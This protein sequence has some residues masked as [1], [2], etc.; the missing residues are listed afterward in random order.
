MSTKAMSEEMERLRAALAKINA[1]RNSI[2]GCQKVN[3]S[4]HVYPLVAALEAAGFVGQ[5]YAEARSDA[6]TLLARA[7]SAEAGVDELRVEV[8]RLNKMLDVCSGVHAHNVALKDERG[9]LRVDVA[10]LL[11]LLGR[12][13]TYVVE[14]RATTPGFTRL[15]RLVDEIRDWLPPATKEGEP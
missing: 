11:L 8:E 9:L 1:I 6:G 14:D 5:P 13:V 15:A 3:W 12:V 7:V 2:V 10:R 4:E